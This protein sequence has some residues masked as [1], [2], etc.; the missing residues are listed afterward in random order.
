[1]KRSSVLCSLLMFCLFL[2]GQVF[3]Q[4]VV[5]ALN[6]DVHFDYFQTANDFH[7][8]GVVLSANGVPPI[9][10]EIIIFG[11][12]GTG[13]WSVSNATLVQIG[14]EEWSFSL[15]FETDGMIT[16]CQWIHFGVDFSV[17][18]YNVIRGLQCW[19]TYYGQPVPDAYGAVT[20]FHV[21][22][23]AQT[24]LITN[25]T[26]V[27][28][29]IPVFEITLSHEKIPLADMFT[30][31]LGR[32]TEPSPMYPDLM[33]IPVPAP[34]GSLPPGGSFEIDL[35]SVGFVIPPDAFLLMRGQQIM[36][37]GPPGDWGWFWEQHQSIPGVPT[38]TAIPTLPPTGTPIPTLPPTSTAIPTLP[39]TSTAIPT[40][41]PTATATSIPTTTPVPPIPGVLVALNDDIHF[42]YQGGEMAND[43]HVEG[44]IYSADGVDPVLANIIIFGD[45]GTGNWTVA[46]YT[47]VEISP[48]T[49]SFTLD[50]VTD[51]FIQF[52]QWIHFGFEF[53]VDYHNI[54][55]DLNGWW[56]FNG[57]PLTPGSVAISGFQADDIDELRPGFQTLRIFNDTDIGIEYESLELAISE[58][59]VPLEDMF[60]TGLG[61]P[62]EVSPQY[63]ELTWISIE[64]IPLELPPDSFFDVFLEEFDIDIPPGQ[65][66]LMRGQQTMSDQGLGDWGWFWHQH[67]ANPP[68]VTPT[69]TP[70]CIH[71]G[72]VNGDGSLTAEDAQLAFSIALAMYTPTYE[73]ECAADCNGDGSVTAGDAQQIFGAVFGMDS[74][75]DPL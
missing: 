62:G 53:Y 67:G 28:L 26:Q 33:W 36:D 59:S 46:N 4:Q 17:E 24:I 35:G 9:I 18:Y 6:D 2:T 45:P 5:V 73:E 20:G 43:F 14:P 11:D 34:P 58:T 47:L 41:P 1:M 19:W 30:T 29:S 49:W 60:V 72:D 8:E 74:C 37:G 13:N 16:Y 42:D 10:S 52:C 51:G 38:F 21:D 70:A 61:R 3:A 50:F 55:I 25:D 64:E 57:I 75:E 54:V 63:P 23:Q 71:S 27:P 66:L 44:T 22:D 56:T 65:F 40:L 68:E 7:I 12:P 48:D 39:P 31:G 15:D 32:P 69:P